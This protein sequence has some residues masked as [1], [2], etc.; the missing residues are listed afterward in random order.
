MGNIKLTKCKIEVKDRSSIGVYHMAGYILNDISITE[1]Y[2]AF[3]SNNEQ[4]YEFQIQSKSIQIC[5]ILFD[6]ISKNC[7]AFKFINSKKGLNQKLELA[8][9]DK[10]QKLLRFIRDKFSFHYE[11]TCKEFYGNACDKKS[12]VWISEISDESEQTCENNNIFSFL[13][14]IYDKVFEEMRKCNIIHEKADRQAYMSK[15]FDIALKVNKQITSCLYNYIC[16]N[17]TFYTD[18]TYNFKAS[19]IKE[20]KLPFFISKR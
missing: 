5:Y 9:N 11:S 17:A 13:D 7:E 15:L 14:F 8:L 3:I 12:V 10:E 6:L 2:L 4:N 18:K 19:N 1:K 20:V 16:E